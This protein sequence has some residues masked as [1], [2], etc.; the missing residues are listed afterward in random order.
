MPLQPSACR[1]D[2]A[3]WRTA[4]VS[5]HIHAPLHARNRQPARRPAKLHKMRRAPS[6]NS[7]KDR[8]TTAAKENDSDVA[9]GTSSELRPEISDIPQSKSKMQKS[10]FTVFGLQPSPELL[11]I[12]MGEKHLASKHKSLSSCTHS[13]HFVSVLLAV[14]FV[15]GILGLARLAISFFYKDEFHLDPATVSNQVL[16][17]QVIFRSYVTAQYHNI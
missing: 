1:P 8:V 10:S 17:L 13:D 3:V 12:S 15:Q 14:Y 9:L 4:P 16:L 6:L 2:Q 11:S 7:S 5:C